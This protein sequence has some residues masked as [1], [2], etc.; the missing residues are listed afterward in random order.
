MTLRCTRKLLKELRAS[1]SIAAAPPSTVLGDWYA[2]IYDARPSPIVLSLNE[3]SLLAVLLP[4]GGESGFIPRFR[5]SVLDLLARIGVPGNAIDAEGNAM[6]DVALG[7]TTNRRV[8][9]CLNEAAFAI[10]TEFDSMYER[11]F[12]D[13][14]LFLSRN[15]YSTTQY[16]PPYELA[17]ELFQA[18][19]P[20][21]RPDLALIH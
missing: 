15:I 9:G 4:F 7:P 14:E 12:P 18:A 17:R 11:Y 16:R 2:G 8:L 21:T 20:G 13:H 10:S 1:P 19:R 5:Q 3:R 6:S